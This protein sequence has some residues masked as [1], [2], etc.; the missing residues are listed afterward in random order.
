[1]EVKTLMSRVRWHASKRSVPQIRSRLLF[2]HI[3]KCAGSALTEA[4]ARHF[5][6]GRTTW[7][8]VHALAR[9]SALMG[10]PPNEMNL[11]LTAYFLSM[12]QRRHFLSG[13]VNLSEEI[14]DAFASEWSFVTMLRNP[15]SRWLSHYFYDRFK[16]H[17][18]FGQIAEDLEQFVETEKAKRLGSLMV[19]QLSG[20]RLSDGSVGDAEIRSA[21]RVLDHFRVV[22]ILEDLDDFAQRFHKSL[23]VRLEVRQKNRSPAPANQMINE[24]MLARISQLCE[25]DQ[26][27]YDYALHR[28]S[29]V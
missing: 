22:G 10:R 23:G 2:V 19:A 8:D 6:S 27:V 20:R 21:R 26:Q 16:T 13:H 11:A 25:P 3:P 28:R 12:R 29:I 7:F 18:G 9:G 17:S 24:R 15:T 1:M 5:W 4:I 14:C